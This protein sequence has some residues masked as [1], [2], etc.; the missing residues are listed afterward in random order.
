[1][2]DIMI[3]SNLTSWNIFPLLVSS[4]NEMGLLFSVLITIGL[5]IS[6]VLIFSLGIFSLNIGKI[7]GI[8]LKNTLIVLSIGIFFS[9]FHFLLL[10]LNIFDN[11]L[12]NGGVT[13]SGTVFGT[14]KLVLFY[15][16]II[17]I[18]EETS[19]HFCVLTS[20]LPSIDSVKKGVLFSIFIAL[21]FGFIENILYIKNVAD[22][23][24]F[25]SS[26]VF[27][28]G[29]FRSIFS[30]M[31]HIICSVIVGLYFSRA[32]ITYTPLKKSSPLHKDCSLWICFLHTR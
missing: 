21:G 8:F 9:L 5:I 25:W 26:E 6:S 11:T 29:T 20:S 17:A 7:W 23:Y 22:Q 2:S 12:A 16:V 18:I 30:L 13:I 14:L 31:T 19:K 4:D 10:K 28:T 27:T 32:Y 24:G 1:M 3:F 15:Y